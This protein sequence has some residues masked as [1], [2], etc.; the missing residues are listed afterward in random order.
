MLARAYAGEVSHFEFKSAGQRERVYKSCF[1]PLMNSEGSVEKLMGITEDITEHKAAEE[2]IRSLAFYDALTQLPNRRLL[3]DRLGQAMTASKRSGRYG[4]LMFLDLDN[5]KPLNDQYGHLAGDLLL[6]EAARRISSCVREID[7]VARFGGDE[8]MVM[9]GELD[10]DKTKSAAES[11][12]VAEKIR[13]ILAEPYV[14]KLQAEGKGEMIIEHHCTS[15]IG[16]ALFI[17]HEV[18]AEDIIKYADLAMY[19]AKKDGRNS[20]RFFEPQMSSCQ[21]FGNHCLL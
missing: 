21:A 19:Q 14:L 15:S 1:V 3:D 11:G 6:V 20:I 18:A 7:T 10:A 13:A 8:F 16:V 5:F 17:N 9:L 4:A 12:I 2:Q